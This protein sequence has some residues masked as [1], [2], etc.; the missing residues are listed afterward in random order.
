MGLDLDP[1][2]PHPAH[3]LVCFETK[4]A[5]HNF[6]KIWQ[7]DMDSPPLM[8]AICNGYYGKKN[9]ANAEPYLKHLAAMTDEL[10]AYRHLAE[11]YKSQH[12]FEAYKDALKKVMV[13]SDADTAV[14]YRCQLAEYLMA[15]GDYQKAKPFVDRAVQLNSA[16]ALKTASQVYAGLGDFQKSE[17]YIRRCSQQHPDTSAPLWYLWCVTEEHGN[18]QAASQF[19]AANEYIIDNEDQSVYA[20]ALTLQ[21]HIQ[22][23]I[24][25]FK[26]QAEDNDPVHKAILLM[27]AAVLALQLKQVDECKGLLRQVIEKSPYFDM[28]KL[29]KLFLQ[30]LDA[31]HGG[32]LDLKAIHKLKA[33]VTYDW[34]VY[35]YFVGKFL[36]LRGDKADAIPYFKF[37]VKFEPYLGVSSVLAIYQLRQMGIQIDPDPN[38]A[39]LHKKPQPTATPMP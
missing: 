4:K 5:E 12:K 20:C 16:T 30:A 3:S 38:V 32:K 13:R 18:K 28:S 14:N 19:L 24:E 33:H 6:K 8:S 17:T 15:H 27:H 1:F 31:K 37:T 10:R 11:I 22:T 9:A 36:L 23:A 21:G 39:K 35:S 26:K 34:R 2:N 7:T 25:L 29:A